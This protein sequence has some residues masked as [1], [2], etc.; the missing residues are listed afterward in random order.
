MQGSTFFSVRI[1]PHEAF[2]LSCKPDYVLILLFQ[3]AR[4]NLSK[5]QMVD[6]LDF[7]T[8]VLLWSGV[9]IGSVATGI[10]GYAVIRYYKIS[11]YDV[12]KY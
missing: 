6:E 2:P 7:R 12:T 3:F 4:S 10:L 8:K 11:L 5:D 9:V 1:F